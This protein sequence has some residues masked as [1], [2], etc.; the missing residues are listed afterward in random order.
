[1][2]LSPR[3][4]PI[5]LKINQK[6]FDFSIWKRN[7]ARKEEERETLR[8]VTLLKLDDAIKSLSKKYS[9]KEI[10][11][12]GSVIRSGAFHDNSDIGIEGLDPLRHYAFVGEL[13]GLLKRDVDVVLS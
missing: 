10:F 4:F 2:G 7:L 12:F 9:W 1:L 6:N 5:P 11:I 13:S 8:H 3:W